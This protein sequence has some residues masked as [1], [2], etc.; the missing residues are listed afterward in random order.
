MHWSIN[1]FTFRQS[2]WRS[3]QSS[4]P[5]MT[6]GHHA[7]AERQKAMWAEIGEQAKRLFKKIWADFD[8]DMSA[9]T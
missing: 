4:Y 3:W 7:Y 2:Q 5:D 1:Y 9:F 8:S 6:L